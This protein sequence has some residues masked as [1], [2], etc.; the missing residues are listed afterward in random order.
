M[1]T[2]ERK[3]ASQ[4]PMRDEHRTGRQKSHRAERGRYSPTFTMGA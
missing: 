4:L 2:V 3:V 1:G